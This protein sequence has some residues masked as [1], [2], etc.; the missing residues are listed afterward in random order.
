MSQYGEN[1]YQAF[2][3]AAPT[4]VAHAHVDARVEFIRK[5][6]LHLA[7]AIGAFVL[8]SALWFKLGFGEAFTQTLIDNPGY[9]LLVL[10]GFMVVG[11][12]AESMANRIA[13]PGAQY[14]GLSLYVV[15]ESI[16]F[17]PL[18]WLA[19]AFE[20]H[21][22]KPIIMP[23]A[24]ATILI[25]AGLTAV[26]IYSKKDFTFLRGILT[27]G[28]LAGLGLIVAS[29]IFGFHLGIVFCFAM[30]ALMSGYILYYTSQVMEHFDTTQYISAAMALFA[31]ITTLFWYVLRIAMYIAANSD[32]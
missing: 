13:S 1:P 23:A 29:V 32:N 28:S 10:G 22:G 26:V 20:S 5:T 27:I 17:I 9:W 14:F 19:A 25:F 3:I 16:L 2:G 12:I 6:Y 18:L 7:G 11:F 24:I 15:A 8:L 31:C 30:V 21:F 4:T